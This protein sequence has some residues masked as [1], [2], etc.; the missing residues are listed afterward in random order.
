MTFP[1]LPFAHCRWMDAHSPAATDVYNLSSINDVHGSMPIVTSGWL[2]REDT[3]G[4]TL[5]SEW[6]GQDDY[7]G[8][9]HIPASMIEE[10]VKLTPP[11]AKKK[12]PPKEP[13]LLTVS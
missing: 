4:L 12:R 11:R 7:R 8:I 3:Q 1:K 6:C 5:A 2:L 9:T 13:S 10:V